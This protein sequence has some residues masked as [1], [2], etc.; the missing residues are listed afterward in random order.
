VNDFDVEKTFAGFNTV[1]ALMPVGRFLS[2]KINSVLTISGG[3]D[4]NMNPLPGSLTGKGNLLLV[5][6][7]LKKF[8]PLEKMAS[9]LHIDQLQS[10]SMKDVKTYFEFAQGKVLV[11]PFTLKVEGI[12]MEIGGMH[13]FD[14]SLDYLIHMKVPRSLMGDVGNNFVNTLVSQ[15]NA[16]GVPVKVGDVVNLKVHMGG[17]IT[18]PELTTDIKQAA[19]SLAADLK[20]QALDFARAKVNST[21]ESVKAAVKDTINSLKSQAV[22]AAANELKKQL[23]GKPDTSA[24]AQGRP[25]Q[26]AEAAKGLLRGINPFGRKKNPADTAVNK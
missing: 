22:Q 25:L 7:L 3:L 21:R 9:L 24:A 12:N 20:Q 26:P 2:G 19:G 6:G 16:A 17:T 8:A 11:K 18:H 23:F 4:K 15:V 14:Q 10:F 1:R 13:G 5:E